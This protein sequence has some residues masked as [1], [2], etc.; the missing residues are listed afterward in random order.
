[1]NV[2][3]DKQGTFIVIEGIDGAGKTT[4]AELLVAYCRAKKMRVATIKF[5]QY[6][7]SFYGRITGAYLRGE[8]GALNEISPYSAAILYAAN[9]YEAIPQ[10]ESALRQGGVLVADRYL[11]SNLAH[12]AAK[13]SPKER[14][15]FYQWLTNLEFNALGVPRPDAT[16]YLDMP[17]AQA[18]RLMAKRPA[19]P[20]IKKKNDIHEADPVYLASVAEVYRDLVARDPS[21]LFIN[22]LAAGKL[23]PP[24][25]IHA[26]IVA[27]L[28]AQN[29]LP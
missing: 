23:R 27:K 1:M 18:Q 20:Y 15:G 22:S 14:P 21:W 10:L 4:Q 7:T 24:K 12:Q 6:E 19:R 13:L 2:D 11:G 5:P 28:Q 26:E 9:R 8:F 17:V 3:R 25:E 29:I 16:V